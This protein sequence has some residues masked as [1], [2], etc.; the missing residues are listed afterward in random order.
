MKFLAF[1]KNGVEGLALS[2]GDAGYHGLTADDSSWPGSLMALI[3]NGFPAAALDALRAGPAIDPDEVTI[4]LPIERPGKIV[5][6]GLNY[7]AHAAEAGL[8]LPSVPTV[9]ARFSTGLV[10]SGAPIV[11]PT[12]SDMLDYEA[13]LAVVIGKGGRDIP[14]ESALDH[15]AG[16]T[17]F[18]DGS[19]R[20][21]QLATPQWTVGKNFDN[22]G[23]F[24][25]VLVT[26]D[27]LPAGASGLRMQLKLNG[28][29]MQ[30][31]KTDDL[32]FDVPSLI[33]HLSKAFTLEPGDVIATGTPSGI[34]GARDPKVWMKPGDVCEIEI[35]G[36]GTLTNPIVQQG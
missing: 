21:W 33:A 24:G 18:N 19:I 22:T 10:P 11:R 3:S 15:V 8:E 27:E 12:V 28:E 26:P 29:V 13:E 25:P 20:D 32:I 23:G 14:K 5:C 7:A 9:F 2:E 4:A 16:Y 35:E 31:T 36:I 1:T 6:I 34:G 30:D 17:I